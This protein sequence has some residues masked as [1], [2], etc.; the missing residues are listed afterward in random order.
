MSESSNPQQGSVGI[1]VLD[2]L[3]HKTDDMTYDDGIFLG[4]YAK[5]KKSDMA[6]TALYRNASNKKTIGD[7][8]SDSIK[9]TGSN[10]WYICPFY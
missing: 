9:N 2:S 5:D 1:A 7:T 4:T 3:Y 10:F 8:L 6:F